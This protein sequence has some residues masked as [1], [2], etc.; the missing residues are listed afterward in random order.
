MFFLSWRQLIA[1]KK[2]TVLIL[3]GISLG[4]LLFVGI[5]GVQLGMRQYISEQLLNNTAHILISG[6]D[7][8]VDPEEV[9]ETFYSDAARVRWITAPYGRRGEV[10]LQNYA[11]WRDRLSQDQDVVDFS[12][13]LNVH[14]VGTNGKFS[15]ALNLI[16]TVPERQLRITSI[17]SYMRAGS[18]KD[19]KNENS[20]VVGS[21][22]AKDLGLKVGQTLDLTAGKG[23][24]RPFRVV[25]FV[26]FGNEQIDRSIAFGE[27]NDVQALAKAPGR[28]SEVAVAVYDMDK[29]AESAARWK[30]LSADKVQDWQEANQ[31]F[32]EMIRMQDFVRYFITIAILIVAAFGI[33]NVLTIMITQKRR[34]IAILRAIGYAPGRILELVLYQ[35]LVLGVSGGAI[36]LLF[37]FLLCLWA[38]SINFGFE[39]GGSNHLL[40]SYDWKIYATAFISANLSALIASYIPARAASRM[41]PIEIVRSD[42]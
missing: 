32:M 33:Y 41:T 25:G 22:V 31:I 13:R 27:L 14:V 24:P 34:E 42:A 1:R 35:G 8:V 28:V 3:L 7:R 6:A 30:V 38:G 15:A 26:H 12:P 21:G 17:E 4:T 23:T 40:I 5:S 18:F 2:Q 36:G 9:T 39:I 37:G 20:I 11:G 16:G 29:A 19:L 10:R